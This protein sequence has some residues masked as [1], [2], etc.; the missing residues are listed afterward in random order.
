ME[1]FK[2][3]SKSEEYQTCITKLETAMDNPFEY[4]QEELEKCIEI[5]SE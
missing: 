3:N 4:E 2:D 1:Q 5:V